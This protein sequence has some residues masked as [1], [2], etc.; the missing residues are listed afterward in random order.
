MLLIRRSHQTDG[1]QHVAWRAADSTPKLKHQIFL[2]MLVGTNLIFS[3][4][5]H[6][7]LI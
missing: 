6:L 5:L 1:Y 3:P 7:V 4:F 2:S